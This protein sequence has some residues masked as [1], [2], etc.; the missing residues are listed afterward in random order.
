MLLIDHEKDILADK[1]KEINA[2]KNLKSRATVVDEI[3]S[4]HISS[5]CL[6][7]RKYIAVRYIPTKF[8]VTKKS[9]IQSYQRM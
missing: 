9:I 8:N 7:S 6:S 3:F 5:N 1:D 4:I 2:S